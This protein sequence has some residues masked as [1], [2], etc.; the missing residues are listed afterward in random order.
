MMDRLDTAELFFF[1][2]KTSKSQKDIFISV[3]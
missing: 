3:D 1:K 2:T